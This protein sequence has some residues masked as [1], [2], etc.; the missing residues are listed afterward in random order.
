MRII[1]LIFIE[2]VPSSCK[3][4]AGSFFNVFLLVVDVVNFEFVLLEL[5]NKLIVLPCG[6]VG[7]D[8][9]IDVDTVWNEQHTVNAGGDLLSAFV[10]IS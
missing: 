7:V 9:K 10:A 5:S 1:S 3:N 4:F 8:N 2:F 6:G